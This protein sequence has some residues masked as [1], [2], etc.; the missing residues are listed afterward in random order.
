MFA[1]VPVMQVIRGQWHALAPKICTSNPDTTVA[2]SLNHKRSDRVLYLA[3]ILKGGLSMICQMTLHELMHVPESSVCTLV[4][5]Q[6]DGTDDQG[7]RGVNK[8]WIR[9]LLKSDRSVDHQ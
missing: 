6:S 3:L 8:L 9:G 7:V 4:S 2:P 1:R 5:A